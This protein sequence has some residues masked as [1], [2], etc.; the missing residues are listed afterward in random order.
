MGVF[1]ETMNKLYV[2]MP[3]AHSHSFLEYHFALHFSSFAKYRTH[4]IC[5]IKKKKNAAQMYVQT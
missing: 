4:S 3:H 1:S 5:S 2:D